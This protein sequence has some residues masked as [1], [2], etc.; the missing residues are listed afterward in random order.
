MEEEETTTGAP[1]LRF[2][3]YAPT[4]KKIE[5]ASVAVPAALAPDAAI[6]DAVAVPDKGDLLATVGAG[7]TFA[8]SSSAKQQ[9]TAE[10]DAALLAAVAP[11]KP[12]W[13]LKRDIAP[14]LAK[15][16]RRTRRAVVEL[17]RE[18]AAEKAA[19]AAAGGG[20]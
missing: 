7:A 16:E 8:P 11:K 13:D 1:V 9:R 2:R 14:K 12:A 5:A 19:A 15:L 20:E 3:N 18:K 6:P 10:E 4:N 17:V